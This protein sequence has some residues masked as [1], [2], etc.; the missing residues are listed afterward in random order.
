MSRANRM[1]ATIWLMKV[2]LHPPTMVLKQSW[3]KRRLGFKQVVTYV[4]NTTIRVHI[5]W[6]EPALVLP[7]IGVYSIC[8]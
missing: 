3:V 7:P 5:V 2:V 8:A 1:I 6:K 4:I